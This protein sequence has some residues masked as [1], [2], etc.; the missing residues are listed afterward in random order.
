M[1]YSYMPWPQNSIEHF[2]FLTTSQPYYS[3]GVKAIK[4]EFR[5]GHKSWNS[6]KTQLYKTTILQ[7]KQIFTKCKIPSYLLFVKL[8]NCHADNLLS[9]RLC[10]T[11]SGIFLFFIDIVSMGIKTELVEH[12][13]YGEFILLLRL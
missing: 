8:C 11:Y 5:K 13:S 3:E 6:N 4:R 10:L 7:V 12:N 9:F 1:S 2:F